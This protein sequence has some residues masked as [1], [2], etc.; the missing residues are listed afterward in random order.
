MRL[1]D[2]TRSGLVRL[3]GPSVLVRAFPGWLALSEFADVERPRAAA[4]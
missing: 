3:R 2:A 4:R 1:V